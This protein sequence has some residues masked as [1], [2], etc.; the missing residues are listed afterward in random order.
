MQ[1][2]N[3]KLEEVVLDSY[4]DIQQDKSFIST[5][6]IKTFIKP[7]Y[8]LPI[9]GQDIKISL[10]NKAT[11][12]ELRLIKSDTSLVI[13]L[14]NKKLCT[15]K[16]QIFSY[17]IKDSAISNEVFSNIKKILNTSYE[18]QFKLT[19]KLSYLENHLYK[20]VDVFKL[21]TSLEGSYCC[22][23]M[24]NIA[25]VNKPKSIP[26]QLIHSFLGQKRM[27]QYKLHNKTNNM[28]TENIFNNFI[29][30]SD[31]IFCYRFIK[32]IL[33]EQIDPN[34]IADL[35][36]YKNDLPHFIPIKDGC[37]M[38][39]SWYNTY[40]FCIKY[41]SAAYEM[42]TIKKYN[43]DLVK[44]NNLPITNIDTKI[45]TRKK[46]FEVKSEYTHDKKLKISDSYF[47]IDLNKSEINCKLYL[48]SATIKTIE[49]QQNEI[50]E[51]EMQQNEIPIKKYESIRSIEM[52][53][54]AEKIKAIEMYEGN[55]VIKKHDDNVVRD[56]REITEGLLYKV[57]E[58]IN[59]PAIIVLLQL[60]EKEYKTCFINSNFLQHICNNLLQFK[61]LIIKK[62]ISVDNLLKL[63]SY[64]V[65][66]ETDVFVLVIEDF[67]TRKEVYEYFDKKE[68]KEDQYMLK[69]HRLDTYEYHKWKR[70]IDINDAKL[71]YVL[72][73]LQDLLKIYQCQPNDDKLT[74]ADIISDIKK[75]FKGLSSKYEIN[76]EL[77][78]EYYEFF[79]SGDINSILKKCKSIIKNII[80]EKR[81]KEAEKAQEEKQKRIEKRI[82]REIKQQ[83]K[84]EKEMMEEKLSTMTNYE[85]M[86]EE[87]SIME[88]E[89]EEKKSM[90]EEEA[91]GKKSIIDIDRKNSENKCMMTEKDEE[92]KSIIDIDRKN[93]ENKCM[94]T[95]VRLDL[96]NKKEKE[97]EEL[98][99]ELEIEEKKS[100]NKAMME[101]NKY[102]NE[103]MIEE[104]LSD[105]H[106]EAIVET[107]SIKANHYKNIMKEKIEKKDLEIDHD[108]DMMER[109]KSSN[110][111]MMEENLD[112]NMKKHNLSDNH[113]DVAIENDV[114]GDVAMEENSSTTNYYQA[115]SI[116]SNYSENVPPL[117][118]NQNNTEQE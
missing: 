106:Y 96:C 87:K 60:L 7:N 13:N 68:D 99:K 4:P 26:I 22:L 23:T 71:F 3:C 114:V 50:S 59:D 10:D 67:F 109:N 17:Q 93:T 52:Y 54:G 73:L 65:S 9:T 18:K 94:M 83:E 12:C 98:P 53:E 36:S 1:E 111:A 16:S 84:E 69:C 91:E 38:L 21:E 70:A 101:I 78:S 118:A 33:N 2:N 61:K 95:E 56:N 15:K 77:D 8:D 107:C 5:T 66:V 81:Q 90:I 27:Y 79:S 104:N 80:T 14:Y 28:L 45:K 97:I 43:F 74:Q 6:F 30:K 85:S 37:I 92:K 89:A 116:E 48:T 19:M 82:K 115:M 47:K 39:E 86:V 58:R 76:I 103:A 24:I 51:M 102:S 25:N 108:E 42:F 57:N 72:I 46:T 88:E 62:G 112:E 117:G 110:E 55:I 105:N 113:H 75:I 34:K 64:N 31:P 11:I 44:L 100:S 63:N 35:E 41:K 49:I 20:G 40:S 32:E 29:N